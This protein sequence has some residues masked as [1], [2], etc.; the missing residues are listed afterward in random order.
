MKTLITE[1]KYQSPEVLPSFHNFVVLSNSEKVVQIPNEEGRFFMLQP[2]RKLYSKQDWVY[3]TYLGAG[4]GA[5]YGFCALS[6]FR[7]RCL[8]DDTQVHAGFRLPLVR[9]NLRLSLL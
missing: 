7:S 3:Y 1:D 9:G 6:W 8:R 4:F 5:G 2:K